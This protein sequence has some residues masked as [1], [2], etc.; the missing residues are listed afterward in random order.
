[1]IDLLIIKRA[2]IS[3]IDQIIFAIVRAAPGIDSLEVLLG[4]GWGWFLQTWLFLDTRTRRRPLV[5][6]C[7]TATT[8]R[9]IV[10]L[11]SES[12]PGALRLLVPLLTLPI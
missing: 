6:V 2:V 7:E 11:L 8:S 1:M 12:G 9:V 10:E 5:V 4:D 3:C